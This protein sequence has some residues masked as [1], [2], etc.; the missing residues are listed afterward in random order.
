M[1]L[2]APE[3]ECVPSRYGREQTKRPPRGYLWKERASSNVNHVAQ[4]FT[5]AIADHSEGSL[6]IGWALG[7]D[8]YVALDLDA[9]TAPDWWGQVDGGAVNTTKRGVHIIYRMPTG[10][11]PGNGLAKFPSKGWG[12]YAARVATSS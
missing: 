6:G 12:K 2:R 5:D 7:I 4:D 11:S 8:G 10:M 3:D 9:P 1:P